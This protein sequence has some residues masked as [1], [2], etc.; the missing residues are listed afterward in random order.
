MRSISPKN[1]TLLSTNE[2]NIHPFQKAFISSTDTTPIVLRGENSTTKAR[3]NLNQSSNETNVVQLT[4]NNTGQ[5]FNST[6]LNTFGNL[7]NVP[8]TETR[9]LKKLVSET[10][11]CKEESSHLQSGIQTPGE[12][13]KTLKSS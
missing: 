13:L 5:S 12:T 9:V 7:P 10:S 1:K 8:N 11:M 2:L 4:M 6:G 3:H